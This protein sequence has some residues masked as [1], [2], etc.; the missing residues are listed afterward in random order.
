MAAQLDREFKQAVHR[1]QTF[2]HLFLASYNLHVGPGVHA[3]ELL[4]SLRR[5]VTRP[6]SATHFPFVEFCPGFESENAFGRARAA[7][8]ELRARLQPIESIP[9]GTGAF[10]ADNP[11]RVIHFHAHLLTASS[12]FDNNKLRVKQST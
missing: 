2:A 11:D 10:P 1:F 7:E 3:N 5:P 4:N 8:N 6:G 9:I 12:S